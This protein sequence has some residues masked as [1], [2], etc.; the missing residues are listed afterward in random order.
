MTR[1]TRSKAGEFCYH[2]SGNLE[3]LMKSLIMSAIVGATLIAAPTAVFA[4]GDA[5]KGEKVF[6][7]CKACHMVGDN[8]KNRVG[9]VLNNIIGRAAGKAEKY[10]YSK[11]NVAAGE[12]GLIWTEENLMEYLPNPTTFLKKYLTENGAED[13]AKG[14][15]KMV[16][17]LKKEQDRA[18]VIAYLKTFSEAQTN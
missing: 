15:S 18:D 17:Q 10:R 8:A 6:N 9:P 4:E 14:R 5:A 7:R 16:F 3:E 1:S 13:K 11:I 2:W 12:A